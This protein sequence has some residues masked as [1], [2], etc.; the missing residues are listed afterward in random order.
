MVSCLSLRSRGFYINAPPTNR[1]RTRLWARIAT[2]TT[3]QYYGSYSDMTVT[4]N[5]TYRYRILAFNVVLA[6]LNPVR[7]CPSQWLLPLRRF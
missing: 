2:V 1:K 5:V 6:L 4:N 3:N 7:K